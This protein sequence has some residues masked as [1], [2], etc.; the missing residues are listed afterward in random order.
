MNSS[1]FVTMQFGLLG[2]IVWHCGLPLHSN[3]FLV[4]SGLSGILG[5]WS[6]AVMRLSNLRVRPEPKPDAALRISGPYRVI[7]HPMYLSVILLAVS[8]VIEKPDA[9]A[10][11]LLFLLFITLH[12][13]L[14]YEEDLLLKKFPNYA[15][16]ISV[17]W[18][19]IPFIY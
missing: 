19:L 18:R 1:I 9:I 10:F 17:T 8:F 16:Y 15:A 7:R 12:S 5:L 13:K 3:V 4:V 14:R 2:A 6:I 11:I